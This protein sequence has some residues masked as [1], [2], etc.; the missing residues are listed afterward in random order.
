MLK[1]TKG[2]M[3]AVLNASVHDF[4]SPEVLES[5]VFDKYPFVEI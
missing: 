3:L 2:I 1:S 4:V 5:S